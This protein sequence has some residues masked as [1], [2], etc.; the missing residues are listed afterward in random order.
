MLH[1]NHDGSNVLYHKNSAVLE[2]DS[3]ALDCVF[4]LLMLKSCICFL[5]HSLHGLP[6]TRYF[7]MPILTIQTCS[8]LSILS[9]WLCGVTRRIE[10]IMTQL[11]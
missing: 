7:Q 5:N 4:F 3:I 6:R 11:S 2:I 8:G 9:I 1:E 10:K